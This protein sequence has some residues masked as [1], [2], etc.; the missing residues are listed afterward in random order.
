MTTKTITRVELADAVYS[1][2]GLSRSESAVLVEAVLEEICQALVK[3][4]KVKLSSFGTFSV[5]S[6]KERVGRN[7]RSGVEVPITPR[8]V[9]SFKASTL[10]KKEI[11]TGLTKT[12]KSTFAAAS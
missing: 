10:I 4:D 7:P 5:R 3:G 12:T 1:Q 9:A 6:K 8:R 2:I 11:N